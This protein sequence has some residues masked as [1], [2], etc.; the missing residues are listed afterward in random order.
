MYSY[1]ILYKSSN[2][3]GLSPSFKNIKSAKARYVNSRN[4]SKLIDYNDI[5]EIVVFK[6]GKIHGYYDRDFKLNRCKPV[7]V[8]NLFYGLD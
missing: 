1:N 6:G 4:W 3:V 5:S 7:F 2:K 8:H